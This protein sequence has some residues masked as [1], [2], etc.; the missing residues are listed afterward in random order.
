MVEMGLIDDSWSGR[1]PRNIQHY[2]IH[3]STGI[4]VL[5]LSRSHLGLG[6]HYLSEG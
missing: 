3:H 6:V 5:R 4:A 2:M 1:A